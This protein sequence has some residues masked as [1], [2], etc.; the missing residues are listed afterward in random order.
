MQTNA[1]QVVFVKYEAIE[2]VPLDCSTILFTILSIV[3]M[4]SQKPTA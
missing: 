2:G 3:M 4:D 1:L